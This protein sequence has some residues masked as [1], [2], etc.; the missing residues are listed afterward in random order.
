MKLLTATWPTQDE[1]SC[2]Q[3]NGSNE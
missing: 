1:S 3:T 2:L